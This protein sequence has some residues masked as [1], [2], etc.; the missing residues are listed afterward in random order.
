MNA[1]RDVPI[2]D[3][4]GIYLRE[5]AQV[6]LLTPYQ[7]V[8]LSIQ[9]EA[10]T[11]IKDL[12]AQLSEHK[13]QPPTANETLDAVANSLRQ[14][15]SIISQNCEHLKL[16]APDLGALVSEARAIRQA[17][18]PEARSYLYDYLEQLGWSESQR[19]EDWTA[20]INSLFDVVLLLYLLPEPM[21]D[22]VSEEWNRRWT[23]PSHHKIRQSRRPGEEESSVMWADLEER[24]SDA[25]Q[26]LIQ[27]NLRLVVYIA[28]EYIGR[29]LAFLDLVQEGNVGLMRAAK[30]YDHTKGFRFSTYATWWI[31]QAIGRA[32]SNHSRLIRIPAHLRDRFNQLWG[33]RRDLVQKKGRE[34]TIEELVLES[35]LLAPEDKAAIQHTQA[36]GEPLSPFQRDQLSQA[37]NKAENLIRLSQETL[38]LDTPVSGDASDSE[39]RLGDFIEDRSTP[40]PADT[41]YRR[42]LSEEV[43]SALDSLAAQQRLV[44][45]MRYGLN[46]Q[47]R[48]TLEEIGCH[49]GTTRERA[50]QIE[51]RALRA[52]RRPRYRRE[53]RGFM[54]N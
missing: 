31:R 27:A 33:L 16:P 14:A 10:A 49:L 42:L 11:H 6:P 23:F 43:Q 53:L 48:H 5:I 26:L 37:I 30:R 47:D 1:T 35:D 13:D 15:W 12:R 51:L 17:P 46:G 25:T 19:D 52:L 22:L 50:R 45:E 24:A 3:M 28:K 36:A 44:L 54:L 20:P 40:R 39:A 7:E 34:P 2:D 4:V 32:V 8:W 18:I 29:G 41:A 21:L 9:Q 38:S